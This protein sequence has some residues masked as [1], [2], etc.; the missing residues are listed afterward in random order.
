MAMKP[1]ATAALAMGLA[2][3]WP[4]S[5]SAAQA[6]A[7]APEAPAKAKDPSA[8]VCRTLVLTGTRMSTRYCRTQEEW[9]RDTEQAQRYVQKGQLHGSRRD[10]E[11]SGYGAVAPPR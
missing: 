10:G 3:L 1:I 5:A 6:A 4:V 8:R 9:D 7:P 2:G 11:M